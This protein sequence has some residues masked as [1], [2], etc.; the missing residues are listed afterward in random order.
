[1]VALRPAFAVTAMSVLIGAGLPALT[2]TPANAASTGD[3]IVV[4]HVT[5]SVPAG[6]SWSLGLLVEDG[7][8]HPVSG[9]EVWIG[10]QRLSTGCGDVTAKG[11]TSLA[12]FVNTTNGKG[13][14]R[15]GGPIDLDTTYVFYLSDTQENL[16]PSTGVEEAVHT[17]NIYAWYGATKA[18]I[19]VDE[20]STTPRLLSTS[21][22]HTKSAYTTVVGGA[23]PMTQVSTDGGKHWSTVAS[24]LHAGAFPVRGSD[25]EIPAVTFGASRAGTYLVRVIDH[26][27]K[28]EDPG[29]PTSVARIKVTRRAVP[30][31]LARTNTYRK[32]VG[33]GAVF[34]NPAYDAALAKHVHWM[35]VNN[36][37]QH[38]E[39]PHTPGY[40][41]AGS[42]AGQSSDLAAG[43]TKPVQSV[44][45]WTGAP[46]H[47]ACLLDPYW[48]VGGFARKGIWSGEYCLDLSLQTFDLA[49]AVNAPA[50][51]SL[52]RAMAF[53]SSR[54]KVPTTLLI[55]RGEFPDPI[56]HCGPHSGG[57]AWSVP[58]YFRVVAPPKSD[59]RLKHATAVL[60]SGGKTI[61]PS[62]VI[63]GSTYRGPDAATTSLGRQILGDPTIGRWVDLLVGREL[64]PGHRYTAT[65]RDGSYKQSTT[66]TIAKR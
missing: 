24:G 44:D 66:F 39:T 13:V 55:N 3:H 59:R 36:Q 5:K 26:G 63:T 18:T 23:V 22:T 37:M 21:Y 33:L 2:A 25:D 34:E 20:I 49:R 60:K 6:H 53:P 1:M 30:K 4:T 51:A 46:F 32:S 56:A 48:A 8:N 12:D 38:A 15:L 14:L 35:K 31:W 54:M 57:G 43:P 52:H 19:A 61:K 11:C 28:F 10:V 62:C 41:K 27:S 45:L 9:A 64:K 40:S 58:V 17:H 7:S 42:Y 29:T 47:A 65:M 50:A 16:D